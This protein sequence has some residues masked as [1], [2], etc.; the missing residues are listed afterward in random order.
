MDE[1]SSNHLDS[2]HFSFSNHLENLEQR[3]GIAKK[4]ENDQ[5]I[6]GTEGRDSLLNSS[7][8]DSRRSL[9]FGDAPNLSRLKRQGKSQFPAAVFWFYF[10][11]NFKV[12]S[13][14]SFATA[15]IAS[16]LLFYY[17]DLGPNT[18]VFLLCGGVLSLASTALVIMSYIHIKPWRRHPSALILF[19]T[20]SNFGFSIILVINSLDFGFEGKYDTYCNS[21]GCTALAFF[22][23]AALF[24]GEFWFMT[25]SIDLL[26]SL[27][28]PFSSYQVNLSIYQYT[29]WSAAF[30]SG[31]ILLSQ[32][33]CQYISSQGICWL[34][35]EASGYHMSRCFWG[36]FLGWVIIFYCFSVG[37]MLFTY[38]RLTKGLESTFATR[39]AVMSTTQRVVGCY[40]AYA[41]SVGVLYFAK[42]GAQFANAGSVDVFVHL[43]GFAVASRGFVDAVVWFFLHNFEQETDT[44]PS[45]GTSSKLNCNLWHKF[46]RCF[47]FSPA[48]PSA[49]RDPLMP[50]NPIPSVDT[51]KERERVSFSHNSRMS[52]GAL[53]NITDTDI[54]LTPQLNQALRKEVMHYVSEGIKESIRR[55]AAREKS[56]NVLIRGSLRTAKG[57]SSPQRQDRSM[58]EGPALFMNTTT[59][60]PRLDPAVALQQAAAIGAIVGDQSLPAGEG[61]MNITAL[62][63][64]SPTGATTLRRSLTNPSI[65]HTDDGIEKLSSRSWAWGG[66]GRGRA[67]SR[68]E[69]F[70]GSSVSASQSRSRARSIGSS[71]AGSTNPL[72]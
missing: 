22:T 55:F 54:D 9:L 58:S 26:I 16:W 23:Q 57:V 51:I 45:T 67:P 52:M 24:A 71:I 30:L 1:D 2:D 38:S 43:F 4:S 69:S 31:A 17:A 72:R 70:A 34:T 56:R 40:I 18:N 61:E 6:H 29:G 60:Q 19:R 66:G 28:N 21:A 49:L 37:V 42:D 62:R 59:K 11:A 46:C 44:T 27:T 7:Q 13:I 15:L 39:E 33:S 20:L 36:F 65:D 32:K 68:E 48:P 3:F 5:V 53:S 64:T 8:H 47:F 12:I 50:G 35:L 14:S 41:T 63:T 10:R 25:L